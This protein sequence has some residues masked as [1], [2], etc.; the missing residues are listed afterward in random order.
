MNPDLEEVGT[1]VTAGL[2]A[3]EVDAASIPAR[4]DSETH[5]NCLNCGAAR[6][7]AY[8]S[9]CGQT[10]HLHRS[11]LLCLADGSSAQESV[12]S[13]SAHVSAQEYRLQIFVHADVINPDLL[14]FIKG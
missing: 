11:L 6:S 10:A 3:H 12:Q 2:A 8:C 14:A 13:R 5:A 1:L 9:R 4:H 7:G